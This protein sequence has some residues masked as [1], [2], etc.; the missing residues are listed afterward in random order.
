MK[1]IVDAQ[2]PKSLARFLS[3]RGFDAIHTLDLPNKNITDDLEINRISFAENRVVITKDGDFYDSYTARKEPYKLLYLTTGNISNQDL[4]SLFDKN[5][6]LIIYTLQNGS[7]VELN[8]SHIMV[9][10]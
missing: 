7:V 3:E 4:L 6:L 9:I 2:L 1:F 5:L 8:R 10:F